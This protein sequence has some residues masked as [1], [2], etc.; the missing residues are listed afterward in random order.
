M[1][2]GGGGALNKLFPGYKDKIW[3]KVPVQTI[4]RGTLVEGADFYLPTAQE[5]QRLARHFE[6]YSEQTRRKK[7][8]PLPEISVYLAVALGAS[9][10]HDYFYQR[11]PVAWCLEKEPPHPP[12]YPFWFKSL[13]HSHDIP[14]VRRG[15]EVYRKVCATCHSMEQLHFRHLVGEVLPEKR[16]KQIAAEYDVTDGPNDQGEMYTRPGILGDAFP[17]PY[18][19]EEAARYANGGAYPPDLSLITAARHFG[20]DYL[21]ALLGGYRDPPEGVELRPGL[22]WNV[23]FPGNAIAMPPPLMDEMIDY[24]DG[25]PCNI[26]QMSKDVVNFLTWATEPTA[27]ERKLYGLKCVSAIAIGTVLMTLWWRFY[28]AMYATRRID[29]GKLK[30]L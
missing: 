28:W 17:S 9:F 3:L 4:S 18:P 25:T 8:V 29:F 13:F 23:W 22:Y 21:M 15:Y 20:P 16:V 27:D 10:V 30:Y 6:P 14:S 24:E 26:S 12:S 11:R 1:G 7:K 2:G 19:N 5:Q